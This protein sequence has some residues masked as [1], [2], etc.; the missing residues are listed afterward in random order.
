MT[1]D[2]RRGVLAPAAA[3][4][5]ILAGAL[6]G[7]R[8]IPVTLPALAY[9]PPTVLRFAVAVAV[10]TAAQL[11]LL[12]VRVGSGVVGLAWGESAIVILCSILPPAWVPLAVA[13]GVAAARGLR[14]IRGTGD[15]RDPAAL[16]WTVSALTLAATVASVAGNVVTRPYMQPLGMAVI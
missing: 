7:T 6:V 2:R 1:A 5:V 8:L 13:L 15:A 10:V 9:P 4:L 16:V 12:W 3:L 11:P 14:A